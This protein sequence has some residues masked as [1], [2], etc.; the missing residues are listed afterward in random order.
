MGLPPVPKF[1]LLATECNPAP[2]FVRNRG[3][4]KKKGRG[5]LQKTDGL[6]FLMVPGG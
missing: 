4:G 1:T 5:R 6:F 2:S 3:L